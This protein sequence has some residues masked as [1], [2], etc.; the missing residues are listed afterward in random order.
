MRDKDTSEQHGDG[1]RAER[2]EHNHAHEPSQLC[3]RQLL[4]DER[5]EQ[6]VR[7]TIGKAHDE[8]TNECADEAAR[9]RNKRNG[10]CLDDG[11]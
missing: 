8:H 10:D 2:G 7:D 5:D 4:L 11:Y 9:V 1:I 3:T 6:H